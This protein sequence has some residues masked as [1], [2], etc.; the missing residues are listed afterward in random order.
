MLLAGPHGLKEIANAL[1]IKVVICN[2]WVES[3]ASI[4][5]LA[6]YFKEFKNIR[7]IML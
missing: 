1:G 3:F 2:L 5:S 7:F 6:K 4:S